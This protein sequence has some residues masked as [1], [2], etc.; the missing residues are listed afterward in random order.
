[1]A[2]LHAKRADKQIY[3]RMYGDAA[4]AKRAVV[5]GSF[6]RKITVGEGDKREFLK[7]RLNRSGLCLRPNAAQYF[8]EDQVPEQQFLL[9]YKQT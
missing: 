5:R 4:T 8:T 6:D 2:A 1:V 9:P 7:P 3:R